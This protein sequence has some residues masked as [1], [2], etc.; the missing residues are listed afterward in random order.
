MAT[1]YIETFGCKTSQ[2]ESVILE[3]Q[4]KALDLGKA[5][6]HGTASYIII[7]TCAVTERA[8]TDALK[9]I[10]KIRES[11]PD[12]ILI[13]TGCF[14]QRDPQAAAGVPGV[15]YVAGNYEKA[16]FPE[17]IRRIEEGTQPK[18]ECARDLDALPPVFYPASGFG[19]RTR[20]FVKIQDGCDNRCAYCIVPLV[21]GRSRSVPAPAVVEQVSRLLEGGYREVVLTGI[22]I[23]RYGLDAGL[24]LLALLERLVHIPAPGR[25]R[26]SSIECGEISSDLITFLRENAGRVTPHLHIPL[27]SGSPDILRAMNRSYTSGDFRK[28][29]ETC[30]REIPD[31]SIGTD[32]ITGFPGETVERFRETVSLVESLPLSYLHVFTFS[33]RPG[34]PAA[35]MAD[36]VSP[37]VRMERSR[38]LRR[39]AREK[40]LLFRQRFSGRIRP[41]IIIDKRSPAGRHHFTALTDNYIR[42]G[43]VER[44]E[45]GGILPVRIDSVTESGTT[46]IALGSGVFG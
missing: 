26:L 10:R 23:G 24:N 11:N 2:Y 15:D 39:L 25:L 42:V 27:Q 22:H 34:T 41:S 19:D 30:A 3:E 7:N 40:N 44:A 16:R 32:I 28:V 33:P 1:F 38:I 13:L 36:P 14:P 43:L 46:G 29:V 5:P 9:R 4:L 6:S 21:R 17:I 18:V 37:G 20:A 31:L 45:P 35:A 8:E 12:S